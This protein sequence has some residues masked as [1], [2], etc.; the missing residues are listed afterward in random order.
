VLTFSRPVHPLAILTYP[1]TRAFQAKFAH[2]SC[3]ALR[4]ELESGAVPDENRRRAGVVRSDKQ[5]PATNVNSGVASISLVGRRQ[6][7]RSSSVPHDMG[8]LWLHAHPLGAT[9]V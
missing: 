4:R 3:L 5:G 8:T 6:G 2:D 1:I 9:I 7:R